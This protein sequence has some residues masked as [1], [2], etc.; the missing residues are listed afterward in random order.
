MN[1]PTFS[2]EEEPVTTIED[3]L[4]VSSITQ[5]GEESQRLRAVVCCIVNCFGVL[6]FF[7]PKIVFYDVTD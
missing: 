7:L 3:M 2:G 4:R 1:I 6:H 5:A